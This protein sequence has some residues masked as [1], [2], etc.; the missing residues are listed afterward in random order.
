MTLSAAKK[1]RLL[2]TTTLVALVT[3]SFYTNAR[4]VSTDPNCTPTTG[5]S[6]FG[7]YQLLTPLPNPTNTSQPLTNISTSNPVPYILTIAEIL[8]SL[9][10]V[11]AV[12]FVV[13]GGIV[14]MTNPDNVTKQKAGMQIIKNAVFGL[15]LLAFSYILIQTI[16]PTLLNNP[17]TEISPAPATSASAPASSNASAPPTPPTT[18]GGT[19]SNSATDQLNQDVQ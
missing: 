2:L 13:W 5:A 18:A 14:K 9:A 1:F 7:C 12:F 8:V 15:L 4:A 6:D 19:D 11:V 3:L 16:N 17:F 10:V